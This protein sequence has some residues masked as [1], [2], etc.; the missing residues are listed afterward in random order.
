MENPLIIRRAR[1]EDATAIRRMVFG[2]LCEYGIPADPDGSD[3]DIMDFGGPRKQGV[4]H[5]TA[6]TGGE[7]VGSA[8][9][10]PHGADRVKLS[11]LF[12][13]SDQRG[14]GLG[15]KLLT[16]A[17]A[18]ARLAGYAEI[19]LTTRGVY[20]QAVNLY[21][22]SGWLRGPD[23]PPPGPDRL[24]YLPLDHAG[25]A[26]GTSRGTAQPMTAL[27]PRAAPITGRRPSR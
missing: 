13:R 23:Q 24:Y 9:L 25:T 10:T 2:V 6:E 26:G 11:K 17:V 19:F 18:Q 1:P 12:L 8:I 7:P 22:S 20:H 16:A 15:R 14:R 5:L 27:A 4:V 21:E 3:A